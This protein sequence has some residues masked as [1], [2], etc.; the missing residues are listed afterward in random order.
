MVVSNVLWVEVSINTTKNTSVNNPRKCFRYTLS[1]NTR[2]ILH[3]YS[4]PRK[5]A[6]I[7]RKNTN[8][9]CRGVDSI[10]LYIDIDICSCIVKHDK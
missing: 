10:V 6:E 1:E 5:L 7:I 4:C 8:N 3:G 2:W 9:A